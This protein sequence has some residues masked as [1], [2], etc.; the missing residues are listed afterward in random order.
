MPYAPSSARPW[1]ARA[2]S[3]FQTH[4]DAAEV[5]LSWAGIVNVT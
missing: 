5:Y 3:G 1:F 2:F 4:G